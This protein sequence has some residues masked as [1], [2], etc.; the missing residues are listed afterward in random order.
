MIDILMATYNG[1]EYIAEQIES[2]INQSYTK[3]HLY[4]KDDCS[5]DDTISIALNFQ[6]KYP[7]KIT[8][9]ENTQNSGSAKNNFFSMLSVAKSD[10][11]MFCDQDDVWLP[12]KI[13]IT[14]RRMLCSERKYG[15]KFPILVHTDVSLVDEKLNIIA[16]SLFKKEKWYFNKKITF[17]NS[18]IGNVVMGCTTEINKALLCKVK[19]TNLKNIPM[20]DWWLGM[21]AR[22]FGKEIVIKTPTM[23]YRQHSTNNVGVDDKSKFEQLLQ[24]FFDADAKKAEKERMQNITNACTEFYS[25]YQENMKDIDKK[26][27]KR[28]LSSTSGSL[29]VLLIGMIREK[30][31][32]PYLRAVIQYALWR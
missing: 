29:I 15:K 16:E 17:W 24:I 28:F 7:E 32:G 27:L 31:S 20:H 22:Y 30:I 25:I 9:I 14:H 8:V 5:K 23:F 2:I 12:D 1:A 11:V 6:K 19:F 26:R 10:Y 21:C 4:I 18:L 3:W 13:K